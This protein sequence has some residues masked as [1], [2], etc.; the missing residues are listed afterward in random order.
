MKGK[1]ESETIKSILIDFLKKRHV[2]ETLTFIGEKDITGC[3]KWFQIELTL[4][5]LAP[6]M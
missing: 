4:M 2:K 1:N 3:E 6:R 5:T